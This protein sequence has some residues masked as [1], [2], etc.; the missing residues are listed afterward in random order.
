MSYKRKTTDV[1]HT[2]PGGPIRVPL[3]ENARESRSIGAYAA[4][5]L[6]RRIYGRNGT[7]GAF[8][9][10]SWSTDNSFFT[11]DAFLGESRDD[12]ITGRN[13]TLYVSL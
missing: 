6:A 8:R 4:E 7:I 2:G 1:D 9:L 11:Y 13:Y 12:G 3:C 10:D 5:I